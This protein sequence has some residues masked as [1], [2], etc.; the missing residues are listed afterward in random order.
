MKSLNILQMVFEL[1]VAFGFMFGL[2]PFGYL[3]SMWSVI[4]LTMGNL[5]LAT[6]NRNGTVTLSVAN[7]VMAWLSLVPIIGYIPRLI[8]VVLALISTVKC[9]KAN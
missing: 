9:A 5:V 4:P 6:L 3:F 7:V 1:F 2:V 8:G